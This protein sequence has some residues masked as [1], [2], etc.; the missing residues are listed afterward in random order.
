[1]RSGN[2]TAYKRQHKT[3]EAF[4]F[5]SKYSLQKKNLKSKNVN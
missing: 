5:T 2:P 4:T 1:M 3:K